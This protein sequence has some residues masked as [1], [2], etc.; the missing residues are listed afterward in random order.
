MIPYE[1]RFFVILIFLSTIILPIFIFVTCRLI[2][3]LHQRRIS[4]SEEQARRIRSLL[5]RPHI[6]NNLLNRCTLLDMPGNGSGGDAGVRKEIILA[7]P[8]S[9]DALFGE[10]PPS[11]DKTLQNS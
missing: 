9:Y 7:P 5:E 4:A 8:P 1:F 3:Y 10:P 6:R 2:R 11:Y